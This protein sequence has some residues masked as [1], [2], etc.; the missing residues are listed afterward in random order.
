MSV[1]AARLPHEWVS[2]LNDTLKSGVDGFGMVKISDMAG[3]TL[4]IAENGTA[5]C[6]WS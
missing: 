6:V 1:G 2:P 4:K 5:A 3:R